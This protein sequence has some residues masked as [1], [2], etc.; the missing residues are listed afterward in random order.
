V[1]VLVGPRAVADV[2]ADQRARLGVGTL[3][4]LAHALE[5]EQQPRR[6]LA[7]R[8]DPLQQRVVL[9]AVRIEVGREVEQRLREA[10]ARG[11]EDHDE[12]TAKPPVPADERMDGLELRVDH[13]ALQE[14]GQP[15]AFGHERFELVEPGPHLA[16]R[17]RDVDGV[18]RRRIGRPDPVLGRT[19]LARRPRRRRLAPQQAFV[20]ATEEIQVER[21]RGDRLDAVHQGGERVADLVKVVEPGS[22]GRR[23][24]LVQQDL[25][26]GHVGA[27][28]T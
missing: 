22:G 8:A 12:D 7:V 18:G 9:T 5:E 20:Q 27:L 13:R 14:V 2:L 28:D 17:R 15:V 6:P 21:P 10:S 19:E 24:D 1:E 25:G 4:R 3:R 11:E 26:E 16:H 23:G